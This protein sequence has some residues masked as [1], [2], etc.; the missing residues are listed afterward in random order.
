[1]ENCNEVAQ[2]GWKFWL[3]VSFRTFPAMFVKLFNEPKSVEMLFFKYR[4]R[5][6]NFQSFLRKKKFKKLFAYFLSMLFVQT[7]IAKVFTASRKLVVGVK[8]STKVATAL[9]EA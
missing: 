9:F 1:M 4:H 2:D 3:A 8:F 5:V 6:H 7:S